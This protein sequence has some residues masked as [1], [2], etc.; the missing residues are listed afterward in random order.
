MDR[1]RIATAGAVIAGMGIAGLTM[2]PLFVRGMSPVT[3]GVILGA[4]GAICLA[5]V[6]LYALFD[7]RSSRHTGPLV[8]EGVAH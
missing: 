3:A 8:A 6:A 1:E 4:M 2:S 7:L 5:G